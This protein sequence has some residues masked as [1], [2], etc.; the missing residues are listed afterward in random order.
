MRHETGAVDSI[1]LALGASLQCL[2]PGF[3][4]AIKV[5]ITGHHNSISEQY[6]RLFDLPK[7]YLSMLRSGEAVPYAVTRLDTS[8]AAGVKILRHLASLCKSGRICPP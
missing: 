1:M 2:D 7:L 4:I 6:I 5:F 3:V 8:R